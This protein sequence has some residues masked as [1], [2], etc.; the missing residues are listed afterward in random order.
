MTTT[1]VPAPGTGPIDVP[2]TTFAVDVEVQ[3][4]IDPVL[5]DP[6]D[7]AASPGCVIALTRIERDGSVTVHMTPIE[8]THL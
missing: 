1:C 7:C 2:G 4:Q 5:G 8:F 6:V 3:A